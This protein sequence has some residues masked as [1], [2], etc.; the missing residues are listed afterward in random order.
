[1]GFI[2]TQVQVMKALPISKIILEELDSVCS[3]LNK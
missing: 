1:M 3:L 2:S